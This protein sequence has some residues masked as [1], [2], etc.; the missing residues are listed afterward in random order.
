MSG[1]VGVE[2]VDPLTELIGDTLRR[3]PR[4]PRPFPGTVQVSE[5]GPMPDK[6]P[7]KPSAKKPGKSLKEKRESK[8]IKNAKRRIAGA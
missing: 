5:G 2:V 1:D 8:K 3:P 7:Q 4:R 6:S